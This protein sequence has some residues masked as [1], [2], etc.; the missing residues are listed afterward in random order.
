MEAASQKMSSRQIELETAEGSQ[1]DGCVPLTYGALHDL[2]GPANQVSS[3][4]GLL[5]K[6]YGDRLGPEGEVMLGLIQGSVGRLQNL[7]EGFRTYT[8]VVG[9]KPLLRVCDG[10]ALLAGSLSSVKA[11]IEESGAVI[12]HDPLPALYCDPAQ[13]GH[14]LAGIIEN[15]LK[16]R[17][18]DRCEVHVSSVLDNDM[19]ILSVRDNGIGIDSKHH[20]RI[21]EMFKRLHNE[22]YP[23][24][25]VG[26]AI[27]E[28]VIQRHGGKIWVE[29]E[30]ERG[31]TF[32]FSLP[33][34]ERYRIEAA[35]G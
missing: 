14:I 25:G 35:V 10:N 15:S 8:R 21:F 11:M 33:R 3:L 19:A 26:L 31:A 24:A 13:I 4:A 7:L 23:G 6:Q 9:E 22:R 12:T 29:S 16:F 34:T 18:R 32:F 27:A 28:R 5:I 1:S 30:L 2:V 20:R 17:N